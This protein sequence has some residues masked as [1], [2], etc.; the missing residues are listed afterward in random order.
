MNLFVFGSCGLGNL[1]MHGCMVYTEHAPR[2]Q[3]F[4]YGT[5]HVTTNQRCNLSGG[6]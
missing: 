1:V 5:S 2:Q 3:Q 6:S 4:L